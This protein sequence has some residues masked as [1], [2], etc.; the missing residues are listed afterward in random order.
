MNNLPLYASY[1]PETVEIFDLITVSWILEKPGKSKIYS[2]SVPVGPG[3]DDI[4]F[5]ACGGYDDHRNVRIKDPDDKCQDQ[6]NLTPGKQSVALIS[7]YTCNY[8]LEIIKVILF[9]FI[10]LG[11]RWRHPGL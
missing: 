10:T 5:S 7:W 11:E 9:A 1:T 2:F 6:I 4:T 3:P 8:L